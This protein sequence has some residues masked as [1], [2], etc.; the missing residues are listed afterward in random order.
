M[1]SSMNPYILFGLRD[2][3]FP[4]GGAEVYIKDPSKII[5]AAFKSY[6]NILRGYAKKISESTQI[7]AIVGRWG[8]GKTHF[9]VYFLKLLFEE[10]GKLNKNIAFSYL[11][12][13]P[14]NNEKI[15][16]ETI[17][18]NF[19]PEEVKEL[20]REYLPKKDITLSDLIEVVNNI[21]DNNYIVYIIFDQLERA[22]EDSIQKGDRE[23]IS[24]MAAIIST[25]YRNV[26]S[27]VGAF[28]ALGIGSYEPPIVA[29]RSAR[30]ELSIID[31]RK[32][33]LTIL[34]KDEIKE[35]IKDYIKTV[36]LGELDLYEFIDSSMSRYDIERIIE[37]RKQNDLYPF[38][39]EA[40]RAIQEVLRGSTTPRNICNI[41]FKS[42]EIAARSRAF[43]IGKEI[44]YKAFNPK[45]E[46][47][48]KRIE[49]GITGFRL[50]QA[51]E[52]ILT[53]G[54]EK[55]YI[56]ILSE[57]SKGL[58]E[59]L[60]IKSFSL[61]YSVYV[62]IDK[63]HK[64]V[65][66]V[67]FVYKTSSYVS[68]DDVSVLLDAYNTLKE[69]KINVDKIKIISFTDLGF[70]A[71]NALTLAEQVRGLLIEVHRID[72]N[73]ESVGRILALADYLLGKSSPSDIGVDEKNLDKE[74]SEV[75][76][77]IILNEA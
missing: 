33:Q 52:K 76:F 47:W 42:L 40:I 51:I 54:V 22:V 11:N 56:G 19:E 12:P 28:F 18:E 46:I 21:I 35:F 61:P 59:R 8:T 34:S 26:S 67:K 50:R 25:L 60:G 57:V 68:E 53:T 62:I 27:R 72:I 49:A 75:I 14:L 2:N 38:T 41:A 13:T 7:F 10:A 9:L 44:I 43:R 6:A 20:V 77:K 4:S 30:E 1:K 17:L 16:F 65:Y 63:K 29:L 15:L 74:L 32:I 71:R 3:P 23:S 70:K 37:A 64:S 36:E 73:P 39:E 45:Y 31:N 5:I 69:A 66:L 55:D 24:R 48:Y 58:A